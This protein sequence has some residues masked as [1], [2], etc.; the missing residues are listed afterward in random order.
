[1]QGRPGFYG[2][3]PQLGDFVS[4]RLP[5][6]FIET[7]DE[8]LQSAL[9]ASREQLGAGWLDRYLV[10][11]IW[12]FAL[13]PGICSES[14]WAGVLMPSVDRVG[15]YFPLTLAS[16]I[17]DPSILP[18]LFE[19]QC[20]WF[21]SLEKLALSG[22]ED[23]FDLDRFDG[24]LLALALPT[25]PVRFGSD[26]GQD[27]SPPRG[28]RFALRLGLPDIEQAGRGFIALSAHL[29]KDFLASYSLWSTVGSDGIEPSLLVC[30]GL[31]PID[32]YA[33]LISG[34]WQQRGWSLQTLPPLPR[35]LVPDP[36]APSLPGEG[37]AAAKIQ[38]DGGAEFSWRSHGISV[39][40]NRR[41]INEDACLD[42]PSKGL[43]AVAD[44]MGGHQ[45]GE[46]A[47]RAI[48]D[49][50]GSTQFPLALEE[51]ADVVR[52][53]LAEVNDELRRLSA[54]SS[55]GQIIGSTV[56]VLLADGG[57]CA[58]LWAGD[59]RLYRL[60]QGRFEQ[61]TRDH[62]MVQQDDG[63]WLAESNG[64]SASGQHCNAIT[65]AVGA[66]EVLELDA[67]VCDASPGDRFLLCSDGLDKELN[68]SE[69]A[70][71]LAT[72]DCQA[73]A[74]ALIETALTRKGRDN[75]TVVVVDA[76]TDPLDRLVA[77]GV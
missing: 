49:A 27:P 71:T 76:G 38:S 3:V 2:K 64:S 48:V 69:I 32:A 22:L 57:R 20:D 34:Q 18:F 30:A 54:R 1:M 55:S 16:S 35:G 7:W 61:L 11:P 46:V 15:R 51:R 25:S 9:A 13:S 66:D 70:A 26:G 68:T 59:S 74:M 8:W 31:P 58:Y 12:R 53:C 28:G 42:Q 39:V 43:W 40:G 4:R 17:A 33:A 72:G 36:A 52:S 24:Q 63:D 60:R 56:V 5:R 77:M 73:C 21:A 44:G 75:V 10:S 6:P 41:K 14:A 67:G 19:P 47:S 23:D 65:R 62:A 37:P 50:L 29:L 45:A